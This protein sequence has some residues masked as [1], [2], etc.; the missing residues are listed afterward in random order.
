MRPHIC[1]KIELAW[2]WFLCDHKAI[3]HS[4]LTQKLQRHHFTIHF[5]TT[6]FSKC[7]QHVTYYTVCT[8][9]VSSWNQSF[10]KKTWPSNR[11][12]VFSYLSPTE[13]PSCPSP[14]VTQCHWSSP[15]HLLV[16][17]WLPRNERLALAVASFCLSRSREVGACW[18]PRWALEVYHVWNKNVLKR[19]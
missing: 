4:R 1:R 9:Y 12:P 6:A 19:V 10:L 11:E 15:A 5:W 14:P 18:R 17:D 13:A 8:V 16:P 3:G 2:K 7:P